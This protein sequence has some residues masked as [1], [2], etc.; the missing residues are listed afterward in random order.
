MTRRTNARVA[1]IAFLVYFAAGITSLVLD[2]RATGGD[3]IAARLANVAAHATDVRTTAVLELACGIC[4]LVLAVTLYAITRDVDRDV[5]LLGMAFRLGEGFAGAMAMN[6]TLATVWL[7]TATGPNAPD[8]HGTQVLGAYLFRSTGG[9]AFFF[10]FGSLL[11]CSLLL[12]GRVIP[13]WLAWLGVIGSAL[14]VVGQ[15]LQ[16]LRILPP[17]ATWFLWGPMAAFEIPF[18][19]WLIVR[20]AAPPQRRSEPLSA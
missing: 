20:G 2:A 10:P 11:F 19:V 12:R 7:A 9:A 4:A 13:R 15:P 14:L 18:A 5:A 1:G 8:A 16:V 3:T 6:A 17:A